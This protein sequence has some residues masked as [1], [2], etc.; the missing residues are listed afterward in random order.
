MSITDTLIVKPSILIMEDEA[1][2][3]QILKRQLDREGFNVL[4]AENGNEGLNLL[5][6]NPGIRI[7]ITDL[8]M[9]EVDGFEVID[10]IRRDELH[11]VYIIVLTSLGDQKSLLKALSLGADDY[12]NKPVTKEELVLRLKVASRIVRLQGQDDLIFVLAEMTAFKSGE[13]GLHLSRIREYCYILAD[14][15]RKEHPELKLTKSLV[16]DISNISVLHDIGKV[17]IPDEILRKS[18]S[19][20]EEEVELKKTHASLGG[21]ILKK[22][23]LKNSSNY[24]LLGHD[25]AVAH[26]ERWDGTG[27]PNKLI[28]EEIPLAARIMALAD[29]FD[30]LT[31]TDRNKEIFSFEKARSIILQRDGQHFD[32]MIVQSYLRNELKMQA[33]QDKVSPSWAMV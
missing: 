13:S 2:Q 15:L 31:A 7:V 5:Q 28:G 32:P 27:Y 8:M 33:V 30:A 20:A 18:G 23:Y 6:Q 14:D 21:Q 17:G 4:M 26:H 3:R 29:F 16:N 22:L 24:L 19:L 12:I 10:A 1:T 25:I 9:P 11:Y